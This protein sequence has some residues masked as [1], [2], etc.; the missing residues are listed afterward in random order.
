MKRTFVKFFDKIVVLILGFSGV[1]CGCDNPTDEYGP[2][3]AEYGMPQADYVIKG[4]VT[5]EKTSNPIQNI[6][7]IRQVYP[8][9]GDTLYTNSEGKYALE[10]GDFPP[11]QD[12]TY[13]LKIEDIDGEKNGGYFEP[14]EIDVTV[15]KTDQVEKGDGRWYEGKFVKTQD[16]ELE[17]KYSVALYGMPS[18]T[19]KP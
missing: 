7:V 13:R 10:F 12:N 8:E 17:R 5:D 1:L 4:I 9:Y 3:Y 15:T 14:K 16:V 6:R 18:A 11:W 19:F 2:V